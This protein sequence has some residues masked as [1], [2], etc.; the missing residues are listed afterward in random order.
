MRGGEEMVAVVFIRKNNNNQTEGENRIDE[1]A[2]KGSSD[3]GVLLDVEGGT[4]EEGE[5]GEAGEEDWNDNPMRMIPLSELRRLQEELDPP[6]VQH[7]VRCTCINSSKL[8]NFYT[9]LLEEGSPL[10]PSG[11]VLV[12]ANKPARTCFWG[13]GP[14][15][16]FVEDI[17]WPSGRKSEYNLS[18]CV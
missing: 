16:F 1:E 13:E 6:P 15:V 10:L 11:A 2:K 14:H 17:V 9:I 5:G 8:G 4:N 7:Q 3:D 18:G 12:D